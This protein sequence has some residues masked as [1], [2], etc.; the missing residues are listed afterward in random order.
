[1]KRTATIKTQ[2][3]QNTNAIKETEH[4]IIIIYIDVYLESRRCLKLSLIRL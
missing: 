2:T 1:M 3:H 4:I